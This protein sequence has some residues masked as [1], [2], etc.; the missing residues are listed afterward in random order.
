MKGRRFQHPGAF[1]QADIGDEKGGGL[2]PLKNLTHVLVLPK[3]NTISGATGGHFT[4]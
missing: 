2:A 4:P 1:G 3:R